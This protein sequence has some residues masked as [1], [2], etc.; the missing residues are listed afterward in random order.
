[1]SRGSGSARRTCLSCLSPTAFG[2]FFAFTTSTDFQRIRGVSAMDFFWRIDW[3][4]LFTPHMTLPE[5]L[6]RGT[7][8]YLALCLLLRVVLKRQIG[9]VS[10]SDLLV[11]SIV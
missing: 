4:R 8:T 11:V 1:M 3:G 6:I 2:I 7:L 5:I 10:M 9:K